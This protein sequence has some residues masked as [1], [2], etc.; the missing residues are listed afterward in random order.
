MI[1]VCAVFGCRT[2]DSDKVDGRNNPGRQAHAWERSFRL[3]ILIITPPFPRW[4]KGYAGISDLGAYR[5]GVGRTVTPAMRKPGQLG[6]RVSAGGSS[7][8]Q[9][10]LVAHDSHRGSP[11][12][13]TLA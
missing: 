4:R 8:R 1:M 7:A 10:H 3:L 6:D 5:L 9:A 13:L 11:R 12:R 2:A